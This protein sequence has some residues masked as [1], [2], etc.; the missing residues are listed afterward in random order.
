MLFLYISEYH[1]ANQSINDSSTAKKIFKTKIQ[2]N[3][4]L[5]YPF[6]STILLIHCIIMY[7]TSINSNHV[8]CF[9]MNFKQLTFFFSLTMLLSCK[10]FLFIVVIPQVSKNWDK[11]LFFYVKL[12]KSINNTKLRSV[13]LT[14]EYCNNE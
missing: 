10:S 1:N 3:V 9:R 8:I 13:M 5:N 11:V 7:I 12:I 14:H 2:E 4:V 6:V